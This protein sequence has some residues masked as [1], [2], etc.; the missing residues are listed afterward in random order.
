MLLL[1][2]AS[3]APGCLLLQQISAFP[4]SRL[5]SGNA[6][7]ANARSWLSSAQAEQAATA[8]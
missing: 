6:P 5:Q 8:T 2:P 1:P 7:T 4:L 3:S